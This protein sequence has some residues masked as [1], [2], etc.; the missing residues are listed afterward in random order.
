MIP[1]FDFSGAARV[2][3]ARRKANVKARPRFQG[4]VIR[5]NGERARSG[6]VG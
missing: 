5:C 3:S 2:A 4:A 1:R 6:K